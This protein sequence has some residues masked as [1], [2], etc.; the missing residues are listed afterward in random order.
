[1]PY[2]TNKHMPR[3]RKEAAQL[4]IRK[5]WSTRK[6]A[7]H[8][9]FNQST[10]VRWFKKSIRYGYHPIPTLSSRPKH[11]PREL[12]NELVWKI[13][14]QRIKTRRCA[15]V[16]HQ[17]LL[18][19]GIEVSLSSVKRTLDRTGLLKKRSPYK[20][21]HPH[22]DRPQALKPGDLVEIDTI[23]LMIDEKKRIYI[24]VLIDTY[25]R[26]VYAKAYE[27]IGGRNSLKFVRE[28]EA[29]APFKF[30]MLQSDH[31]PEFGDWFVEQ[32]KKSH[33]YTRIGKPNDNSHIE[34]FNRTLQEE[35]VDRVM[36]NVRS[37][38]RALKKYLEY[39]NNTRLHMGISLRA[40]IQLLAK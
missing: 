2:T 38:N 7:R 24:Y 3:I 26:W 11:H 19:Q 10:I 33:R 30:G 21:F 29:R 5:K 27:K 13:F 4:L 17:E 18:N 9:G 25:S 31:G 12:S 15:E 8:F 37:L 39:Y 34:R 16:V 23:H 40:P 35:C 36:K 32:V 28:A 14:Q 1:M 6:V 22:Q 20:R